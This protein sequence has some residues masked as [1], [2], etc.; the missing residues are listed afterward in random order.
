M[1]RTVEEYAKMLLNLYN[2]D[3]EGAKV[4]V[5]NAAMT[6][7]N[8]KSHKPSEYWKNVYEAINNS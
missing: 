7:F 2:G 8:T 5:F 1:D 6:T 3:K 4:E